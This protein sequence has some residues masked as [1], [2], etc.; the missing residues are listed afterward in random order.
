MH[1]LSSTSISHILYL[2]DSGESAASIH[3]QTG[4]G[5]ATIS[6]LCSEHRPNLSKPSGG[7]PRLLTDTSI[8]YA[9]RV[10][11]TGKVNNAMQAAVMLCNQSAKKFSTQTLH[12]RLKESGM[13]AVVKKKRPKLQARHKRARLEFAERHAEWTIE[14]WKK[15]IWS[16]ETKI[17]HL[18]SDGRKYVRKEDREG[19]SDRL[20]EGTVKF[21]GG[22]LMMWGCM[23]WD[24]VGYATKIDGKMDGELY[25]KILGNEFIKTL[26]Y[27]GYDI[28]DVIF[29]QD[30]D[31]KHTSRKAKIWFSDN[32]VEVLKWPAQ[33]PDTN[34]IEHLWHYLKRRLE[35]YE[36]P[37]KSVGELWT[38][39]EKEW[40]GIPVE[41][42]S[43]RDLA[44]V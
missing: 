38:R 9:N 20:V 18:G 10:I 8:N 31:P 23:T 4:Y 5:I 1:K 32:D 14:D 44:C 36:E 6:R 21:G 3:H 22:N 24:G 35:T 43:A 28:E 19:L 33:S 41:V 7:R 39:V 37:A 34:P 26:E 40:D 2:L 17:N 15:V 12:R 16:D 27:F 42:R 25:T 30:N 11:R 29:Q 13:T